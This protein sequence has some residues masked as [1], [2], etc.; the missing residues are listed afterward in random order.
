MG[1]MRPLRGEVI[2]VRVSSWTEIWYEQVLE[3]GV[4]AGAAGTAHPVP[5]PSIAAVLRNG[6]DGVSCVLTNAKKY[7]RAQGEL[8]SSVKG[9]TLSAGMGTA[10][11]Q[12]E[13]QRMPA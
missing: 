13:L 12:A 8:T 6:Q 2:A 4:V 1:A 9:L 11:K 5:G 10:A 7:N 3:M